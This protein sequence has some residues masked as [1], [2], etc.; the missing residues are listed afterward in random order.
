MI[1]TNNVRITVLKRKTVWNF[2][3]ESQSSGPNCTSIRMS[4]LFR[5]CI[6]FK[7]SPIPQQ[8]QL[9]I[10]IVNTMSEPTTNW[11]PTKE[12]EMSPGRDFLCARCGETG[13]SDRALS[14]KLRIMLKDGWVRRQYQQKWTNQ[15]ANVESQEPV[16][17]FL[18]ENHEMSVK[19]LHAV[20]C[21]WRKWYTQKWN[22]LSVPW[23]FRCP[24][25]TNLICIFNKSWL[26]KKE[27]RQLTA[28]RL[29]SIASWSMLPNYINFL[30]ANWSETHIFEVEERL[31][32]MVT[33]GMLQADIVVV[34]ECLSNEM[35]MSRCS[36]RKYEL[37]VDF[38]SKKNI[39]KDPSRHH[40]SSLLIR[41]FYDDK[42][43]L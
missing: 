5:T 25:R 43:F 40:F 2:E 33:R 29:A 16:L 31:C 34:D 32:F 42:H 6:F 41:G 28:L 30:A 4:Q 14:K 21:N 20:A 9:S 26:A 8:I 1:Y 38:Q 35:R 23:R 17:W 39:I 7:V 36:W 37:L 15:A 13:Y 24:I 3:F 11:N 19:E 27:R 12:M 18:V 22:Q 10:G